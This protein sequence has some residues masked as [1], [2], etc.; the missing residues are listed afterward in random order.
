MGVVCLFPVRTAVVMLDRKVEEMEGRELEILQVSAGS[1]SMA[2]LCN[3][4]K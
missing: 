1:R 3:N 2:G 4:L